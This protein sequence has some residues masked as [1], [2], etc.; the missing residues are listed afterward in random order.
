LVQL[1]PAAIEATIG[2]TPVVV[3]VQHLSPGT[4]LLVWG[5][6]LCAMYLVLNRRRSASAM[7]GE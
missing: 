5:L 6:V 2:Q 1:K 7:K 4:S 3:R